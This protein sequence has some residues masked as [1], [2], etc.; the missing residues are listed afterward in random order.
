MDGS[1][2]LARALAV[3]AVVIVGAAVPAA[4]GTAMAREGDGAVE[5]YVD[6]WREVNHVPGAAVAVID[7]DGV[8]TYVSG[9]DGDGAAVSRTTPFLVGSVAKTF[10]SALVLR[11]VD[12]GRLRLD[13]PVQEHLPWLDAPRVSVRQLLTHTAGYTAGDGLAV[14]ERFDSSPGALR[15]AA[16]DLER[17]G[18]PGRYAYN[19]ADYLVLGALI[20]EVTGR[21]FAS[22]VEESLFDPVGMTET[23]ADAQGADALPPGH[24]QW[25]GWTRAYDPGFDESGASY[26]YVVSTLDDLT[27][28]ARALLAG[29]VLPHSLEDEAWS[30]QEVTGAG[31]GYGYGWS[32]EDGDQPRVHH[33]GATPGYFAHVSLVPEEG[34]AVVVLANAYAEKRAPS[35]AAAAADI[36]RIA[37]GGSASVRGGDP[38]LTAAPWLLMAFVPLGLGLALAARRG[39]R[40]PRLRWACAAVAALATGALAVLPRL[41]GGSFG[42]AFTW[43]PDLALGVVASSATLLLVAVSCAVR[44]RGLLQPAP[45]ALERL[46]GGQGSMSPDRM[47]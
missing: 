2:A 6:S 9:E 30:V 35:L 26:G 14:S 45:A 22:V 24:R 41:L 28:Y 8:Q 44:P 13:D 31:R 46:E 33:T 34:R 4:A 42:T 12:E 15:R 25:W 36:D 29:E 19:S 27:T 5:A 7:A 1:R 10:T 20:E 11:L 47:A 17:H 18:T 16:G 21:S 37:R 38:I 23:A 40:S 3:I 43:L 32:V 39:P